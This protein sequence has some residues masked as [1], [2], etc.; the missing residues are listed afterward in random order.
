[1]QPSRIRTM[2]KSVPLPVVTTLSGNR[3]VLSRHMP[4]LL[5]DR[6]P[7]SKP[8]AGWRRDDLLDAADLVV[9]IGDGPMEYHEV[10][11]NAG[12]SRKT[13]SR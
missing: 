11:W 8:T 6:S 4:P 2:Y 9:T 10:S 1:M 7:C 5:G 12:R 3:C 13:V